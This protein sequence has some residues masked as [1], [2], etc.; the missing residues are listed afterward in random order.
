MHAWKIKCGLTVF[1]GYK[2]SSR[3]LLVLLQ[4]LQDYCPRFPQPNI[5]HLKKHTNTHVSSFLIVDNNFTGKCPSIKCWK[6]YVYFLSRRCLYIFVS[7]YI[8]SKSNYLFI[9]FKVKV[10]V[11]QVSVLMI[12]CDWICTSP[13]FN[14]LTLPG[15]SR[16]E[17]LYNWSAFSNTHSTSGCLTCTSLMSWRI[18]ELKLQ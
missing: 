4:Q 15:C 11:R 5:F 16:G 13:V 12:S 9:I 14:F 2:L 6:K 18:R 3:P 1:S 10:E 8:S 7:C 17:S